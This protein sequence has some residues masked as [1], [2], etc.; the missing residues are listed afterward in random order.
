MYTYLI[1]N[2][3][4]GAFPGTGFLTGTATHNFH[5]WVHMSS[6]KSASFKH[7]YTHL[8]THNTHNITQCSCSNMYY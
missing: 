2:R 6:N 5:K 3:V 8:N 7:M 4:V 1:K